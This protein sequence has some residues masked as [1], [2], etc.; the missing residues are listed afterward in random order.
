ML[1]T[2]ADLPFFFFFLEDQCISLQIELNVMIFVIKNVLSLL[3][4]HKDNT[5]YIQESI[6]LITRKKQRDGLPHWRQNLVH[7]PDF[8]NH[9]SSG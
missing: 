1:K 7:F 2:G 5:D 6:P 8:D 3:F 4:F 9:I